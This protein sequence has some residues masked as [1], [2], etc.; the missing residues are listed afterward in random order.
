MR[1]NKGSTKTLSALLKLGIYIF[2]S[3]LGI[4]VFENV[5][6]KSFGKDVR[7]LKRRRDWK[8]LQ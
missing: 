7:C 1:P 2:H 4:H 6:R 5:R 8:Q 3:Q